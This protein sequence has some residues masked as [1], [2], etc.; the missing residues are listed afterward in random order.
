MPE[1]H[2][3]DSGFDMNV[4]FWPVT[5]NPSKASF[6]GNWLDAIVTDAPLTAFWGQNGFN[7][8]G[9]S[10]LTNT[11]ITQVSATNQMTIRVPAGLFAANGVSVHDGEP[12]FIRV[13]MRCVT[14]DPEVG[15]E[16]FV[17]KTT[18]PNVF[19]MDTYRGMLMS[20]NSVGGEWRRGVVGGATEFQSGGITY[21][22]NTLS[23]DIRV[24]NDAGFAITL[25]PPPSYDS[26]YAVPQFIAADYN[27]RSLFMTRLYEPI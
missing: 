19:Y 7:Y 2:A 17:V 27:T 21:I 23:V 24:T 4:T 12:L 11:R 1:F 16:E 5:D 25:G 6:T 13:G 8:V 10:W 18:S 26:N 3:Q 22:V 20:V 14:T 9:N 15:V